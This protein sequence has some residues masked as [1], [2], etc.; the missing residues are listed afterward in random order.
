M[1]LVNARSDTPIM[2]KEVF[3]HVIAVVPARGDEKAVRVANASTYGLADSVWSR[4]RRLA[5]KVA[6]RIDAGAV[7]I[8]DHLMSHELAG[9]FGFGRAHAEMGFR[10]MLREQ[11]IVDNTLPFVKRNL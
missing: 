9:D 1:V 10:E 11:V 6:G 2:K 4:N 8:D 5:R 3:G 7:I